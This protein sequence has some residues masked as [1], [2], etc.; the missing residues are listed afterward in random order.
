MQKK[1]DAAN[2]ERDAIREELNC[3]QQKLD[4]AQKAAQL[5]NPA[6]AVFKVQFT[7]VQE[8]FQSLYKSL[9][10]VQ[11]ADPTLGDKLKTAVKAMLDKLYSDL[12]G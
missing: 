7:Q 2:R 5:Q 9:L 12:E 3:T 10:D 1:L 11:Q 8:D 6:A 4:A